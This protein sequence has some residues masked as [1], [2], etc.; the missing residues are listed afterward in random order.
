ML[1]GL[2]NSAAKMAE[3]SE[4]RKTVGWLVGGSVKWI[5]WMVHDGGA[6]THKLGSACQVELFMS[7]L[8]PD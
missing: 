5:V 6:H 7:E 3:A 4:G 1:A 2:E 8:S